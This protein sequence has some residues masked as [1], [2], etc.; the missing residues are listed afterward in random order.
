MNYMGQNLRRKYF[1]I[2]VHVA[3]IMILASASL[4]SADGGTSSLGEQRKFEEIETFSLGMVGFYGHVSNQEELYRS[5]LKKRDSVSFFIRIVNSKTATV[6]S[7]LYAACGLRE[8][9]PLAFDEAKI[10]IIKSGGM[11]SVLRAD[12]LKREDVAEI[13][14]FIDDHGCKSVYKKDKR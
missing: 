11:A 13:I 7:K 8:K 6:E 1:L 10:S 14:E 5:I 9:S 2:V 12:I 4:A 3:I